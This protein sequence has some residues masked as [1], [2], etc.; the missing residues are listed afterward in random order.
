M[1]TFLTYIFQQNSSGIEYLINLL[2]TLVISGFYFVPVFFVLMD[3]NR[4][5]V[6][7]KYVFWV[8]TILCILFLPI[9]IVFYITYRNAQI[10]RDFAKREIETEML[11]NQI[12]LCKKCGT[13]TKENNNYCS[14]C[15]HVLHMTCRQCGKPQAI[16]QNYCNDCGFLLNPNE[17]KS[18]KSNVLIRALGYKFGYLDIEHVI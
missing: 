13:A 6:S 1:D 11:K 3:L 10:E 14:K 7:N 2:F 18:K 17:K 16:N 5:F 12:I 9:F 8:L 4:R 15:G